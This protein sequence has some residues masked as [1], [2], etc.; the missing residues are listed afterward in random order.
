[1]VNAEISVLA[2]DNG[3]D[4]LEMHW[5]GEPTKDVSIVLNRKD[6]EH[7][8]SALE[9]HLC[10]AEGEQLDVMVNI[11]AEAEGFFTQFGDG[12]IS[13]DELKVKCLDS[14]VQM[15]NHAAKIVQS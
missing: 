12:L 2:H 6:S 1:M 7:L 8:R 13:Y 14:L 10:T 5:E 3:T 4:V 11:M 9:A 15:H